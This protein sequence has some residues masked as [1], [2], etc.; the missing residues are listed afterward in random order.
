[1]D[2]HLS[3]EKAAKHIKVICIITG[4]SYAGVAA[5]GVLVVLL[6]M[7]MLA[8]FNAQPTEWGLIHEIH[9]LFLTY[10]PIILLLGFSYIMFGFNFKKLKAGIYKVHFALRVISILIPIAYCVHILVIYY[11]NH[12]DTHDVLVVPAIIQYIFNFIGIL[13]LIASFSI[14]QYFI[15]KKVKAYVEVNENDE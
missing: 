4:F 2:K 6:Q 5:M 1:M 13:A 10:L 9:L 15:H 7:I 12:S 14:P 11:A 8:S 3:K